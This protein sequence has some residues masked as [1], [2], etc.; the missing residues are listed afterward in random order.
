MQKLPLR[1]FCETPPVDSTAISLL[2]ARERWND[3]VHVDI[4]SGCIRGVKGWSIRA[5]QPRSK[6]ISCSAQDQ[7]PLAALA[8]G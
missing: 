4:V 8:G 6:R 7:L 2:E 5:Q 1:K 3:Q